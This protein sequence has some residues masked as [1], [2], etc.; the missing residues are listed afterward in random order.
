M[1]VFRHAGYHI[2]SISLSALLLALMPLSFLQA[3]DSSG[4][5]CGN[6][7]VHGSFAEYAPDTGL[8]VKPITMN[9][10]PLR[11]EFDSPETGQIRF[12]YDK[13]E[14]VGEILYE[15]DYM[16]TMTYVY[17]DVVYMDTYFIETGSLFS[18]MHQPGLIGEDTAT[19]LRL[20]CKLAN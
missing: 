14:A 19:T 7:R 1:A 13:Q 16:R 10:L 15:D 3:A 8:Q 6:T 2:C 12:I 18:S 20:D 17:N 11:Y 4:I 9:L 5:I